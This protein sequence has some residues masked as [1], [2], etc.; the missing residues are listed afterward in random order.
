MGPWNVGIQQKPNKSYG[1][2]IIMNILWNILDQISLQMNNQGVL[3]WM[4]SQM[5]EMDMQK[6]I[7]IKTGQL[8]SVILS[9]GKHNGQFCTQMILTLAVH[10][11]ILMTLFHLLN[12]VINILVKQNQPQVQ[13]QHQ[14]K[15]LQIQSLQTQLV[16]IGQMKYQNAQEEILH[17]LNMVVENPTFVW[18]IHNKK[19]LKE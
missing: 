2:Q 5:M 18:I 10:I 6:H 1:E 13:T 9:L 19:M 3:V 11:I 8:P 12:V 16:Q 17:V 14:F 4:I 15:K 7:G